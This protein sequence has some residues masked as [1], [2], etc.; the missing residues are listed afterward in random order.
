MQT[1]VGR[2]RENWKQGRERGKANRRWCITERGQS[3]SR[4]HQWFLGYVEWGLHASLLAPPSLFSHFVS[5][6]LSVLSGSPTWASGETTVS[7]VEWGQTWVVSCC[8]QQPYWLWGKLCLSPRGR[9]RQSELGDETAEAAAVAL[10]PQ[11]WR[12][13]WLDCC[14]REGGSQLRRIGWVGPTRPGVT[15]GGVLCTFQGARNQHQLGSIIKE[16]AKF[17][18]G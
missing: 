3:F 17:Q 7:V 10:H 18:Q 9:R 11:E 2:W 12:D 14:S 6:N 13:W 5:V 16:E 15:M 8:D 1:Q 4:K